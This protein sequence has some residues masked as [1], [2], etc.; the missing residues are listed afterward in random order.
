MY[1]IRSYYEVLTRGFAGPEQSRAF[2]NDVDAQLPPGKLRRVA[3][4]EN[5]NAITVDD[6][7]AAID[8]DGAGKRSMCRIAPR[9]RNNFV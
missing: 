9:E 1:A 5:T 6:D 4:R 2:E 7:I 3:L 8:F